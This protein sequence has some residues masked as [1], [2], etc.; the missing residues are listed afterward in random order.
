MVKA[1]LRMQ[2]H[3][4][5]VIAGDGG[6]PIRGAQMMQ[7]LCGADE[8]IRQAEIDEIAGHGDV[9]RLPLDD[10]AG[11]DVEDVA[12]MHQFPAAMPVHI[13]KDALRHQLRTPCLRHRAQMNVGE[14][15]ESEQLRRGFIRCL[16]VVHLKD[17]A[18]L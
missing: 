18:R 10:I 12:P 11:Q 1:S 16:I 13:A 17:Q 5:V 9:V 7:P 4:G 15:G 14:M 2:P 3:I 6:D 8:L